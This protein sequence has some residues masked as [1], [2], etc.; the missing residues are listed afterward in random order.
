MILL[1]IIFFEMLCG[2]DIT[3]TNKFKVEQ[4]KEL[5]SNDGYYENIIDPIRYA[6]ANFHGTSGIQFQRQLEIISTIDIPA[7]KEAI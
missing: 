5:P 2:A 6:I 7:E 3:T 1:Q 4:K